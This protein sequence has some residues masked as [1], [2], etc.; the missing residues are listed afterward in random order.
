MTTPKNW[1]SELIP[2]AATTI[3]AGHYGVGKTNFALNLAH[4]IRT[5]QDVTDVTLIDLDIVNPYFRSSDY[6]P[7]LVS[8]GISVIAPVFARS[9]LDTPSLPGSIPVAM[10]N[11]TA[12]AP[13]II[14]VGGDDEGAKV[15]ARFAENV[16][17]PYEFLYVVNARRNLTQTPAEAVQILRE[18]EEKSSL[19]A[20]AL[21]NN[22][23]LGAETTCPLAAELLAESQQ[24]IQ[25]IE[26]LSGLRCVCTTVPTG[27][28]EYAK[29]HEI[30]D[31]AVSSQLCEV[32]RYVHLP[33]E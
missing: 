33:W 10:T 16:T 4:Q 24:Y 9:M 2:V 3:I 13:L 23:H 31:E 8:E 15:L 6:A 19:K 5:Q 17:R 25:E 21:V 11:A 30:P 7:D 32:A 28:T 14:D 20:T 18:I 27:F 1:N 26:R 12:D 22:T 29:T